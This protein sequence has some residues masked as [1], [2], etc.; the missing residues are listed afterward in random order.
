MRYQSPKNHSGFVSVFFLSV[1]L[2]VSAITAVIAANDSARAKAVINLEINN[3]QQL[4]EAE[5]IAKLKCLLEQEIERRDN[6]QNEAESE[7]TYESEFTS[8][9]YYISLQEPEK[10]EMIIYYDTETLEVTEYESARDSSG[11]VRY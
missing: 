10:I 6:L 8:G 2:Y 4:A 7:E 5:A 9:I 3:C 11:I 1:F